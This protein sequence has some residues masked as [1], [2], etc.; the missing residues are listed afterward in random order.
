MSQEAAAS[1]FLSQTTRRAFKKLKARR[2]AMRSDAVE[3]MKSPRL[4]LGTR[5]P[6]SHYLFKALEISSCR[7]ARLPGPALYW[8][9]SCVLCCCVAGLCCEMRV[10]R[11]EKE[12]SRNAKKTKMHRRRARRGSSLARRRKEEDEDEDEDEKPFQGTRLSFLFGRLHLGAFFFLLCI[13]FSTF[14]ARCCAE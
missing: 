14:S 3:M 11:K 1:P 6:I 9:A 7:G 8:C 13:L 10:R 2:D 4:D 5:V 12:E